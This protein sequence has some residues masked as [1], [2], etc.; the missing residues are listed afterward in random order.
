ME[1]V[2]KNLLI[3]L[4]FGSSRG[5]DPRKHSFDEIILEKT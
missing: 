2:I 4:Q 1:S 5:Y 3:S